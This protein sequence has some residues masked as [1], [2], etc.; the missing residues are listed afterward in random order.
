[1]L[2]SKVYKAQ[3]INDVKILLKSRTQIKI[4][5]SGCNGHTHMQDFTRNKPFLNSLFQL[6]AL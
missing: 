3:Q 2:I 1:M 5:P 6:K 4:V